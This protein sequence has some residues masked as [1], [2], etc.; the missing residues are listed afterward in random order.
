MSLAPRLRLRLAGTWRLL[1]KE[2]S[3][4]GVVGAVCFAVDLGL[5]QLLYTRAGMPAVT[6]KL[7]STLVAMTLAYL[8]H[9][10]WS[11][12][13][14]ARTGLRREYL[15]FAVV[16]GVTLLQGLAI[17]WLVRHPLGHESALVLQVANVGSIALGT[18]IRYLA[19]RRWVFPAHD[20]PV[21]AAAAVS[22]EFAVPDPAVPDPALSLK[23]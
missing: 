22:G 3:A 15:L 17:V 21:A 19:Y 23:R 10:Y 7:L 6:A 4:F 14:R 16:N 18:V 5:F 9:R 11:F 8:G 12:S 2:L 20:A 1:L 13:H